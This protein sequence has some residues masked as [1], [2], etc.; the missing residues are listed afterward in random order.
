[1]HTVI[2][3]LKFRSAIIQERVDGNLNHRCVS[4]LYKKSLH[5]NEN[6]TQQ[7][8]EKNTT[9]NPKLTNNVRCK[10]LITREMQIKTIIA[11]CICYF[12]NN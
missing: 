2:L 5:L 11:H 6:K 3:R 9:E 7:K 12:D 4:F 10:S 8:A 1:M